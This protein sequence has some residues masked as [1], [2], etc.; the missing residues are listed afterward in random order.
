MNVGRTGQSGRRAFLRSAFAAAALPFGARAQAALVRKPYVQNVRRTRATIRWTTPNAGQASVIVRDAS[1]TERTFAGQSTLLAPE[2]TGLSYSYYKHHALVTG[3]EPG[4][5]YTYRVLLDGEDFHPGLGMAFR[6]EGNSSFAFLALGD[7]GS[8]STGQAALARR[9]EAEKVRLLIHTGDL[10][11]PTGQY[12]AYERRYFDSYQ[13]MM[14]SVPF[15]PCPGNHDY[16]ET[17][18]NPYISIHDVPTETVPTADQGRYYSFDWGDV[19][20]VSLDTNEPLRE[21]AAGRG[22]MLRWLEQDLAATRKFW[23]IVFFHHPPYAFGPN[24]TDRESAFVRQHIVPIL[25]KFAVP[26][27]LS[28]HEHSYQRTRPINGTVYLTTGGGGAHLYPVGSSELLEFGASVYHYLRA[29]VDGRNLD[30]QAIDSQGNTFDQFKLSLPPVLAQR[31]V[32]NA[33]SFSPAIGAGGLISIFGWQMGL[34]TL[35]NGGHPLR[36]AASGVRVT[37]GD[38]EL[39]LLMVS[40]TQVNAVLPDHLT[41]A[42]KLRVSTPTGSAETGIEITDF[43]PALFDVVT[44]AAGSV[45]SPETP[46]V[47]GSQ[48]RLY[49][50]GLANFSGTLSARLAGHTLPTRAERTAMA[51][52]QRIGFELP[53]ALEGDQYLVS[54]DADG[55]RTNAIPIWT[56]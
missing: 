28:G 25:E 20:F 55:A 41:G 29:T 32:L 54:L 18:A 34:A 33:A 15:F 46:C 26:L 39:P 17:R 24:S 56:R 43:A 8:G 44:D 7:S 52:V 6:T 47:R 12:E 23:R 30:L 38:A 4:T 5:E 1:G 2:R 22:A 42:A 45:I 51:G 9:I 31:P 10:A 40:P 14:K 36:G 49:V 27:V 16:Y 19:H 3:L 53:G 37:V 48:V 13:E 21:A 35:E 50:T 11:Y